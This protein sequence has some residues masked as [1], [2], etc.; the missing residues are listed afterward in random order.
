[1]G[2]QEIA[3]IVGGVIVLGAAFWIANKINSK[4]TS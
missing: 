4:K 3:M 1:M 2:I